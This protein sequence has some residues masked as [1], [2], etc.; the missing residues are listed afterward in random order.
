MIGNQPPTGQ[1]ATSAGIQP[2]SSASPA[3]LRIQ[4]TVDGRRRVDHAVGSTPTESV[5]EHAERFVR[6]MRYQYPNGEI[7]CEPE[8]GDPEMPDGPAGSATSQPGWQ[9]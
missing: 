3:K 1:T 6:A 7:T 4:V 9:R 5:A 2:A 8:P